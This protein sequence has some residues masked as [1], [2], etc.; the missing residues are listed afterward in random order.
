MPSPTRA[1]SLEEALGQSPIFARLGETARRSRDMLAAIAA[2]IP[3]AL[4]SRIQPGPLE[5]GTWCLIVD[6]AAAAAKIRQLVPLFLQRLEHRSPPVLSIRIK[7]R[8]GNAN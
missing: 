4:H 6:G 3:P 2:V 8:S 1:L 7:V 5:E